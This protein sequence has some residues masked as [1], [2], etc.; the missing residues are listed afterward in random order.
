MLFTV[1]LDEAAK[2][3][4]GSENVEQKKAEKNNCE[5]NHFSFDYVLDFLSKYVISE[6]KNC[7]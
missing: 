2:H 3:C 6:T 5:R 7:L 1:F 4:G